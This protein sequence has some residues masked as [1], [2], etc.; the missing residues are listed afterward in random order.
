MADESVQCS[1]SFDLYL[2]CVMS[3]SVYLS[4][5]F[6]DRIGG[7]I[8]QCLDIIRRFPGPVKPDEIKSDSNQ[9]YRADFFSLTLVH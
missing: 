8:A 7:A 3:Q 9:S 5:L 4:Q 6:G 2:H 1:R